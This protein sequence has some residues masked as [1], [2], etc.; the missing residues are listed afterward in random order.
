MSSF[1][2]K[3]RNFRWVFPRPTLLMGVIN[4]TPDSFSGDGVGRNVDAAVHTAACMAEEGA[5]ILDLGAASSRP[6]AHPVSEQDELERLLPSLEAIRGRFSLP[7]SVDTTSARVAEEALGRGADMINDVSGLT[8]D[9]RMAGVCQRY[10]AGVVIMHS[11]GNA[12]TM[13]Q[14]TGYGHVV[15]DV[16]SEL[17]ER[18]LRAEQAGVDRESIAVDPGLGF[19]KTYEQNVVLLRHLER[20]EIFGRPI[21]VGPSRKSFIGLATGREVGDRL[22][23][24]AAACAL[25]IRNGAHVLRVHDVAAMRDV[26]RLADGVGQAF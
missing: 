17:E 6:G 9:S 25:A 2:W 12:R 20:F 8:A 18:F 14:L 1:Q 21:L 10:G 19:A 3:A 5:D 23:G 11:R 22:F 16:I 13:L 24:T 26:A 15:E 4:L 7:L